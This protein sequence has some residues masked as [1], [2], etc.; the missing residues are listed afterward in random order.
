MK[1][2]ALLGA[3]LALAPPTAGRP[4]LA[5]PEQIWLVGAKI[6]V[7]DGTVV[8]DGVVHVVGDTV[9]AVGGA[10]L[11]EK[12]PAGAPTI[13]LQ[14]KLITPGLIA[15]DT[16]LGL[17]E[18]GAESSTVDATRQDPHPVHAG[19]DPAAAIHAESS[20][21]QVQA[22]EGITTAAVSPSGGLFPG[23]VAWIDLVYGDHQGI[24]AR[25]RIAV[26]LDL[27]QGPEQSRAATLAQVRRVLDDA[28]LYARSKGAHERRALRDLAAHP[29][30]LEALA[31]VLAGR[32]PLIVRANRASDILAALRLAAD[33][34]LDIAVLGGAEA[35]KVAEAL[36]RAKVPVVVEP[37]SN[38]PGS[39]EA[40][41]SRLENAAL[42]HRAGVSVVIAHLGEAHNVRNVTQEAGI[43]VAYGLDWEA[44]LSAITLNVA[45]AY[46]MD[47]RYGSVA[48]GKVANLVVWPGDP[49]ELSNRPE[50]VFV[51][52]R[53]IPMTSRQ[54]ILRDRYLDLSGYRP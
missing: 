52:G 24:V 54:T 29:H 13:D 53:E 40:L 16:Q 6:H 11:R 44:A 46:G 10:P 43:A 42:L 47:D 27:G 32:I 5:P 45:R 48:V 22:I 4:A 21:I 23:S 25:P 9:R 26:D 37:S 38:L 31:P 50:R 18:I 34:R 30:D 39:F 15:A 35:W 17:V 12:I 36:A 28:R 2:V 49:F 51:R 19:Y 41:G 7:G 1:I 33:Y 14:G 20:L 3:W 8:E